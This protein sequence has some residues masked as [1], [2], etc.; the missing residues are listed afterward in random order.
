VTRAPLSDAIVL[1]GATGDLAAKKIYPGLYDMCARGMLKVPVVGVARE[2]LTQEELVARVRKSVQVKPYFN[3]DN[4]AKLVPLLRYVSGDYQTADTYTRLRHTLGNAR[5]PL[6][7]LAIPPVMFPVVVEGLGA[8]A[9]ARDAR[10]IVEKPFGRDLTSSQSLSE[11]LESVF[12]EHSVFRIDHYLGKEPVQNLLYFRFANSFLE[13]IW[14]R[15]RVKSVQITM[16]EQFGIGSR[17]AFYEQVGALRD[18]VQNHL[19]QVVSILAMD[20]PENDSIPA[21]QA[22]KIAVLR[23]TRPLAPQDVVRGQYAGYRVEAGVAPDSQVETYVALRLF[24]DSQRWTGVPFYIRAGKRLPTTA[25]EVVVE[26]S[27]PVPDVFPH[28]GPTNYFRFRLGPDR[29]AIAL[30][31]LTKLPGEKMTGANVEL[32]V[33]NARDDEA[34]AYERLISDA[35]KG[36]H[37]LFALREGV[38]AS[39]RVVDPILNAGPQVQMY[40]P[41]SWGPSKA[42]GLLAPGSAWHAPVVI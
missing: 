41:G 6:H 28:T 4:F 30:G 17:G 25:T 36:D 21:Q 3:E 40:E 18:V 19:L 1:F 39:W 8:A 2:N 29:V 22:A 12:D 10:V 14:R 9:C 11:T 7:Y 24:I 32:F 31:A 13:P 15:G 34:D 26:L 38:E 20:A 16:A 23:A 35:M 33:S 37:A 5:H 27:D 42:D